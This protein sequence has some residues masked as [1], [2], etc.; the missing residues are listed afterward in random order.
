MRLSQDAIS[1]KGTLAGELTKQR[2]SLM[3]L[4]A[5]G[6]VYLIGAGPGHPGLIT[7]WG[8]ELLQQCD[9]VAYDALIP[10]E[11]IAELPE[12]VEKHYV[13]KRA[14][15]HSLPQ[16]Q[17]N[18]LLAALAR[19]SLKVVRLKGGDPFIYGRSSEEAEYLA[20]AGIP[21]VMIPG[22]T[23]ASA[24]AAL[25]GFSL[26]NRLASSWVLL[27]TGHSAESATIP[28]PWDKIGALPGG[29]LVVY[30]GLAKLD[31]VVEQLLS[32]GLAQ[33]TPAVAV[34]AASTGLQQ[35]VEASL[36]N[37]CSECRRQELKPPVLVIIGEAVRYRAKSISAEA[38]SL[39]GKTV[40]VTGPSQS[41]ARMCALLRK[42]GAEPIP[43][44]TIVRNRADDIKGWDRFRKLV[45]YGGTCLFQS[46]DE[47]GY[48]VDGLLSHGLDMRSLGHFKIIAV[49]ESSDSAES[50]ESA[51]LTHNI[52]A[53]WV[54]QRLEPKALADRISRLIPDMSLPLILVRGSFGKC[55]LE[56]SLQEKCSGVISLTVCL[57]ST[58]IWDTHWRDEL[59]VNPPD[60]IAFTSAPE[61]EAFVE[62]LG[63]ETA[64][65]LADRSCVAAMNNSVTEM[66]L[67]HG[68]PIRASANASS[69][70]SFVCTLIDK[71]RKQVA[72]SVISAGRI[73]EPGSNRIENI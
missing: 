5:P 27:A 15:R 63:D 8:Y 68:L 50:T 18:E 36:I 59:L 35:C 10:M 9:A 3:P 64:R 24:A 32:S 49:A 65:H 44:P 58:A 30:M 70:D 40:L 57:D 13:G 17:I 34:Q 43:Y 71:S 20:A 23:A 21:V 1:Q 73:S 51:L 69:I 48:F 67:K 16:S 62:L 60:Y 53:D 11:L 45:N 25:S 6:I 38:Q 39:A 7:R 46:E 56:T 28:V 61:V 41:M 55:L 52:K 66:L 47:V 2:I 26:T 29:T 42:Q 37:I 31:R 12:R 72:D 19:R 14:G 22:V 54:L 4:K 33:D